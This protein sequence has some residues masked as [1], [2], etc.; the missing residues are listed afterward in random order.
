MCE[1]TSSFVGRSGMSLSICYWNLTTYRVLSFMCVI[2]YVWHVHVCMWWFIV[3][4]MQNSALITP[5]FD[6]LVCSMEQVVQAS[7]SDATT[8]V[9]PVTAGAVLIRF[10]HFLSAH[11]LSVFKHVEDK[12]WH[13]SAKFKI[14]WP[15]FCQIWISFT[16]L[17]LWIASAR[18]NFKWV[19]IRIE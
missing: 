12:K 17:K 19:N 4:S 15:P 10:L 8:L 6:A 3:K 2:F 9:N 5:L 16:H 11:Y 7:D 14:C 18:N 1:Q 13:Y